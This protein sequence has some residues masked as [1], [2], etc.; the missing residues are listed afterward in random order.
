[1]AKRRAQEQP[2]GSPAWMSTF[3]DESAVVLLRFAFL[4]VNSRCRKV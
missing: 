1:M 3:S 2:A 4:Y